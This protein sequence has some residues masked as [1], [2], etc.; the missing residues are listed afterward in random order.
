MPP[1]RRPYR[2]YTSCYR[3]GEEE[4]SRSD[5]P[6]AVVRSGRGPDVRLTLR[7]TIQC[8]RVTRY[9]VFD[10]R[11]MANQPAPKSIKDGGTHHD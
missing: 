5:T 1:G 8:G 2:R 10:L 4:T 7:F 11:R 6:L 9:P 3:Y